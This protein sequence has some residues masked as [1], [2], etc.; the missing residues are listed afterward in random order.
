MKALAK[1]DFVKA[2]RNYEIKDYLTKK[3]KTAAWEA[4]SEGT[5]EINQEILL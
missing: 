4:L 3:V 5:E 1:K 2:L